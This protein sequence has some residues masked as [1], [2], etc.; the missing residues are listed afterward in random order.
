V[1]AKKDD[2]HEDEQ[3]AEKDERILC[4]RMNIY[5]SCRYRARLMEKNSGACHFREKISQRSQRRQKKAARAR[6]R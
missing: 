4:E 1:G 3:D 5:I 6:L 2:V